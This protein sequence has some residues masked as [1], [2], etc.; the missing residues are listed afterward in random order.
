MERQCRRL[1]LIH[2]PER[3]EHRYAIASMSRSRNFGCC[4]GCR[5][6]LDCSKIG[7]RDH[8]KAKMKDLVGYK[9]CPFLQTDYVLGN[10]KALWLSEA[11]SVSAALSAA[12][13]FG[14][15]GITQR[16]SRSRGLRHLRLH[17]LRSHQCYY[18]CLCWIRDRSS[19]QNLRII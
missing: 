10:Q 16:L 15:T 17:L 6:S 18:P 3:K 7:W 13:G 1:L 12:S 11:L 8:W 2:W 4:R 5:R 9:S 14:N 19:H